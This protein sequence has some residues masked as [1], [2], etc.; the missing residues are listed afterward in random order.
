M[1]KSY[2]ATTWVRDL[3][4]L[5]DGSVITTAGVTAS[6]PASLAVVEAISGRSAAES[7]ARH[8]GVASWGVAHRTQDFGV[9]SS[10]RAAAAESQGGKQHITEIP[11]DD[12]VDEVSLALQ[13]EVWN[14]SMRTK[15]LTTRSSR[16]PIRS[17]RGLVIVPDS[18]PQQGNDIVLAT[19]L[20]A[21]PALDAA[22]AAMG[23]RYGTSMVRLAL[24]GMEYT[25]TT[26]GN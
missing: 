11:I 12:G 15:V 19:Q 16:A 7:T 26:T 5:Q 1:T 13:T 24:M 21:R 4:Y 3:R 9:T 6:I 23:R 14:R 2:P 22:L 18:V 17:R 10:D 8:F 20:P 25:P